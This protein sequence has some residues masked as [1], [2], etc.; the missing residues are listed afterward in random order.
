VA[1][2]VVVLP[3]DV[4]HAIV[5]HARRERP[6]ECCGLLVGRGR[7]VAFAVAMT[8]VEAGT[9]RFRLDDGEHIQLRRVLRAFRPP[10]DII[11]VYHSHPRGEAI[12]SETDVAE[13][14]YPRWLHVIVGLKRAPAA[15]AAFRL[16]DGRVRQVTLRAARAGRSP[17]VARRRR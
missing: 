13:A 6:R 8:N 4:R 17:G 5:A 16:H 15:I 14:A 2:D 11:G 12:P 9:T 10:L 1:R 7:R 3:A